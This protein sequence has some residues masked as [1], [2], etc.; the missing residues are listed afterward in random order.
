MLFAGGLE[1]VGLGGPLVDDFV[2][3]AAVL[4]TSM[5]RLTTASSS[6]WPFLM[7]MAYSSTV[8][9]SEMS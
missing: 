2:E 8:R 3:L 7:A 4:E 6:G 5:T 9:K 1:G